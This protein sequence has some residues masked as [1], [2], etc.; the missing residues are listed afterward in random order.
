M[1]ERSSW[2][3]YHLSLNTLRS[4][5][6]IT[7]MSCLIMDEFTSANPNPV[8]IFQSR[9]STATAGGFS[10][11]VPLHNMKTCVKSWK[12]GKGKWEKGQE[13]TRKK[14]KIDTTNERK[15]IGPRSMW[16]RSRPKTYSSCGSNL[17]TSK[18]KERTPEQVGGPAPL[19]PTGLTHVTSIFLQ[20]DDFFSQFVAN[21][22]ILSEDNQ[23]SNRAHWT[24][25]R[26]QI[27]GSSGASVFWCRGQCMAVRWAPLSYVA[28]ASPWRC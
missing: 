15:F 11:Y 22:F 10:R 2:L 25:P 14:R 17:T 6:L 8:A 19:M 4:S 7:G 21:K 9:Y 12:A 13:K 16:P 1:D 23:F 18:R 27:M 5:S 26:Q 20:I 24:G 3:W 28:I